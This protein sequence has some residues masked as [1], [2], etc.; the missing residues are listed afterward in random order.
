MMKLYCERV[1]LQYLIEERILLQFRKKI[2]NL[3]SCVIMFHTRGT[4][5]LYDIFRE[6]PPVKIDVEWQ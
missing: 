1:L 5:S 6:N 4:T 3:Q 2:I